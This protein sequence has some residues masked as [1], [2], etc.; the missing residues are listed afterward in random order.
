MYKSQQVLGVLR[1]HTE[2]SCKKALSE[3]R[4]TK[5]PPHPRLVTGTK[6]AFISKRETPLHPPVLRVPSHGDQC[7]A[8]SF[9]GCSVLL[10]R[11]CALGALLP[12]ADAAG[13]PS[14]SSTAPPGWP[15]LQ[16]FR[17]LWGKAMG[18][19]APKTDA[20]H[21]RG[22]AAGVQVEQG[23]G[24]EPQ[25]VK[26]AHAGDDAAAANPAGTVGSGPRS[27]ATSG[28]RPSSLGM[29]GPQ[30]GGEGRER[31]SRLGPRDGRG[32][33]GPADPEPLRL[34]PGRGPSRKVCARGRP[35]GQR[36]APWLLGDNR[37]GSTGPPRP[38]SPSP[39]PPRPPPR[40]PGPACRTYLSHLVRNQLLMPSKVTG[41][42]QT[43]CSWLW[44][45]R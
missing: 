24:P 43:P 19:P 38:P 21:T 44:E 37:D 32:H 16:P 5:R 29:R 2:F 4:R 31:G 12:P 40:E 9:L 45:P 17:I 6:G 7:W 39:G 34:C 1:P 11:L 28:I 30:G 20:P 42:A 13:P 23:F 41:P 27:S 8:P 35:W 15:A 3:A 26:T 10:S 22:Q 36:S 18:V 14:A 25:E 33:R